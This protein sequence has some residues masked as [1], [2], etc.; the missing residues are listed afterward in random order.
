MGLLAVLVEENQITELRVMEPNDIPFLEVIGNLE[1]GCDITLVPNN[2][3][4]W[5]REDFQN[6]TK[7]RK[8]LLMEDFYREG[9]KRFQVLMEGDKPIGRKWN[10]DKDNRKPPKG[11]L[12]TPSALWFEV[13]DITQEV[14]ETVNSLSIPTY[15]EIKEFPWGVTRQQALQVLDW[16]IE[17]RL[18]G[19]GT[20]QDAM[21]TGEDT[22]WHS[23]LSPYLNLGLL[24]PLEVI[25]AAETAYQDKQLPLNSVEGFIRQVLGWREYM[26]GIYHYVGKN[27]PQKNWFNH[28]Q[29]LP[30][31][32]WTGKTKMNC[33]YQILSQIQRT[34]YAHHIQRLMV[35]SNFALIAGFSPQEVENWFHAAFIDA[36]DWVMQ[37]NVMGMG[38]FADGGILASK[39]YAASANYI[40][41]MSDYCKSCV[42]NHKQR[43]G[44]D[45]CPFNFFYWDFLHRHREKLQTQGRMT[46][47]LKNLD[48][49]SQK[50]LD[51]IHQQV[52]AWYLQHN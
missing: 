46:F 2:H 4:L 1:L 8:R 3:F 7:N 10:F 49:M 37:T 25:Q 43:T 18:P 31:F 41:K 28:T 35:L 6:W 12:N 30:E 34:G 19:F 44:K 5:S 22:M 42:Y 38:L 24:Q 13:D 47:I 27:Y 23:L 52:Q 29:P 11:K 48:R 32:F 51:S 33:L 45:A 15:G 20:Y 9:R 40:N 16:F 14:I 50:E 36:Y 21:V 39:P 17:N 26:Q